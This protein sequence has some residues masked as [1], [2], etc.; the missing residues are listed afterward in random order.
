MYV[1]PQGS[2]YLHIVDGPCA[3]TQISVTRALCHMHLEAVGVIP[4]P[5]VSIVELG[6]EDTCLVLGS[7]GVFDYMSPDEV[8]CL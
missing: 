4:K 8:R 6:P 7:D 3:G 1:L 5:D 2:S